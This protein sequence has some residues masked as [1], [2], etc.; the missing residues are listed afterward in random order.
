M[1]I[2]DERDDFWDLDKLVP[3]KEKTPGRFASSV[4]VC[5]VQDQ[6][7]PAD[8]THESAA[9]TRLTPA[10]QKRTYTETAYT[11]ENNP[12][13]ER[14]VIRR[15]ADRYDFYDSFRRAA[16]LYFDVSGTPADFVP[17]YS[18]MPQ[19]SQM[20]EE[21]RA[22]YFYWRTELRCGHY[23]RSDY[24]YLYLYVYE[25]LNL[26][27]KI[28][29]E[30]GIA[31][32][33]TLW[34]HYR[35]ELPRIDRYFSVW[36]QDYCLVW[37]LPSPVERL[38]DFIYDIVVS[39]G[40]REFY[41]SDIDTACR[42]GIG[43]LV[44]CLSDY[45]W[46]TARFAVGEYAR[47]YRHHMEG[48][49]SFLMPY[50]LKHHRTDVI[51]A[52][53]AI[54]MRDAFPNSLCTHSVKCRL[55]ITYRPL[56]EQGSLRT[57]VTAAVKYIENRLRAA[58]G[59]KSRLAVKGLPDEYRTRIDFYF[60]TVFRDAITKRE[61]ERVP[62][63][64]RHYDAPEGEMDMRG[65]DLIEN[66]SW[67]TTARLVGEEQVCDTICAPQIPVSDPSVTTPVLEQAAPEAPRTQEQTTPKTSDKAKAARPML[68][69]YEIL[70][71]LLTGDA[72]APRAI[73]RREGAP[74][75]YFIELLNEEAMDIIGDTAVECVD[76]AY[77]ILE[78][79]R[80]EI[81]E[82]IC[83]IGS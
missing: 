63:Y 37:Q 30:D 26:P 40:F 62:E 65:A 72:D 59:V 39:G 73:A 15:E 6:T 29:A 36:V 75:D 43:A 33:C 53:S 47:G 66:E 38:S 35:R 5:A 23:L 11:P 25:I 20:T 16:L 83:K 52:R 44:A 67:M 4:H 51:G 45:D 82:W 18:Y 54:L 28:A 31:I 12:F 80:E 17:F 77:R 78:D 41:L 60:D 8:T 3:K 32:L 19:Y 71:A 9:Q 48:A 76:G 24:S 61:R 34:Q 70:S 46:H 57:F 7:P 79:Y 56:A 68:A 49:L 21:Q 13:I 58:L 10:S 69:Q 74:L 42:E 22:Y 81:Q 2:Q 27:D 55:E 1:A 64:E 14:V 50:V